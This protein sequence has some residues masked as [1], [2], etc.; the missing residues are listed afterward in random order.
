MFVFNNLSPGKY[1]FRAYEKKNTVNPLVYFSG[2]LEPY[3]PSAYFT[4]YKDTV[5]VRKYWDIEGINI[6][7]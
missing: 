6:E 4:I 2:T 3:H 7:F 5:E 1:V